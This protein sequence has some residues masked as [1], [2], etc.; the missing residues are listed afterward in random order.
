MGPNKKFQ[1]MVTANKK[2]HYL[3]TFANEFEAERAVIAKKMQLNYEGEHF[4]IKEE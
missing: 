1:G 3:G 2:K 4:F